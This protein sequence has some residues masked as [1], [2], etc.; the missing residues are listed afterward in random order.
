[1]IKFVLY[2]NFQGERAR[3]PDVAEFISALAAGNNA[4]QI[5]LVC[6]GPARPT[7]LRALL[8]A[9]H[10]TH[11][12]VICILQTQQHLTTSKAQL[13]LNGLGPKV[14]FMVGQAQHLL[15]SGP[16]DAA[17]FVVVDCNLDRHGEILRAVPARGGRTVVVGYNAFGCKGCWSWRRCG[18]K[19]Q[20]H[21]LPIG[22]GLLVSRFGGLGGQSENS[23]KC[24]VGGN[25]NKVGSRWVVKVD[26]CTGE[27]HVFRVRV[28]QGRVIPA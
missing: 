15:A 16:Y 13:G 18:W 8:A 4:R 1:M 27:E 6:S 23:E 9:A 17:D 28:P 14:E 3:E 26:K 20:T 22:E 21:L 7:M 5:V 19:S 2:L 25:N 11:G 24:R 10:Q 12:R